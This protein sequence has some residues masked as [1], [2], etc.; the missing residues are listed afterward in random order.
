MIFSAT[1][2]LYRESAASVARAHGDNL[3]RTSLDMLIPFTYV[4]MGLVRYTGNGELFCPRS[5]L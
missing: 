3:M 2:W 5:I 1:S 4:E